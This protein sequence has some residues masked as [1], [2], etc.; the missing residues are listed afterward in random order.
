M[1]I[2]LSKLRRSDPLAKFYLK[3]PDGAVHG[4]LSTSELCKWSVQNRIPPGSKVSYD[5][6]IWSPAEMVEELKLEWDAKCADGRTMGPYNLLAIPVLVHDGLLVAGDTLVNRISNRSVQVRDL[7]KPGTTIVRRKAAALGSTTVAE[8][9]PAETSGQQELFDPAAVAPGKPA[10]AAAGFSEADERVR[11]ARRQAGARDADAGAKTVRLRESLEESV[12]ENARLKTD[13]DQERLRHAETLRVS[14]FDVKLMKERIKGLEAEQRELSTRLAD[15]LRDADALRKHE[16]SLRV[17]ARGD[18]PEKAGNGDSP[19]MAKLR[20]ALEHEKYLHGEAVKLRE[21]EGVVLKDRIREL[22][23]AQGDLL[24][25][26]TATQQS[27]EKARQGGESLLSVAMNK[28]PESTR[29]NAEFEKI[30]GSGAAEAAKLKAALDQEKALHAEALKQREHESRLLKDRIKALETDQRE[31]STRLGVAQQATD[32]ARQ[33]D[34][35]WRA[36]ARGREAELARRAS[37]LEKALNNSVAETTKARAALEQEK[38]QHAESRRVAVERDQHTAGRI[39]ELE[40]ETKNLSSRLALSTRAFDELTRKEE[41]LQIESRRKE[42]EAGQRIAQLEKSLGLASSDIAKLKADQD[43]EKAMHAETRRLAS[44]KEKQSAGRIKELEAETKELSAQLAAAQQVTVDAR[45]KDEAL[46]LEIRKKDA[47]TAQRMEQLRRSLEARVADVSRLKAEL[48]R[49][50]SLHAETRRL[51]GEREQQI[52]GRMKELE[53]KAREATVR[54]TESLQLAEDRKRKYEAIQQESRHRAGDADVRVEQ[55]EKSAEAAA[56]AVREIQQKLDDEQ[57]AHVQTQKDWRKK[58]QELTERIARMEVDAGALSG[59]L[60]QVRIDAEKQK[61]QDQNLIDQGKTR[62]TQ[63]SQ[64]FAQLQAEHEQGMIALEQARKKLAEKRMAPAPAPDPAVSERE[65]RLTMS[66]TQMEKQVSNATVAM[67]Q[68]KAETERLRRELVRTGERL[69]TSDKEARERIG[70]LERTVQ[71]AMQATEVARKSG[72]EQARQCRRLADENSSLSSR[73]PGL[74]GEMGTLKEA[75]RAANEELAA[76]QRKVD[77]AGRAMAQERKRHEMAMEAAGAER[78][79]LQ[80]KL[81][82][83]MQEPARVAERAGKKR[84]RLVT[85][86]I[87]A[88]AAV[89]AFLAGIGFRGMIGGS[90]VKEPGPV[91][92][93]AEPPAVEPPAATAVVQRLPAQAGTNLAVSRVAVVASTG[94]V[95][96]VAVQVVPPTLKWPEVAVDGVGVTRT[97]RAMVMVFSYGAFSSMANLREQAKTDLGL[98]A[99]QLREKMAGFTVVVVGHTDTVPLSTNTAYAG[100]YELGLARA[101]TAADYLVKECSMPAASVV[102]VSAGGSP[103]TPYPNADAESRKKNRTVVLR[104]VPSQD[105]PKIKA[106]AR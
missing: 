49:E 16:E 33:S 60:A 2:T 70:E 85:L 103:D 64:R 95:K 47:D 24:D 74:Q 87:A 26:L 92:M 100:N 68:A 69:S 14:E 72:E 41:T 50:K 65:K 104:L 51:D 79:K 88:T 27:A 59:V 75:V 42:E 20:T 71:V 97:D 56:K 29:R 84:A 15:A 1:S 82:S 35:A 21:T 96:T 46:Q 44:E 30:P 80:A 76:A 11:A 53:I 98:V 73:I 40:T 77:E 106:S 6:T 61:T 9:E 43:Y 31:L 39:K 8:D 19:E 45:Q 12:E 55:L 10:G 38:A 93:A 57:V 81:T 36:D 34:D 91:K 90:A 23:S 78:D 102:A 105:A 58:E 52:V 86:F 62:E 13:L 28:D 4:P 22:E 5:Q 17:A 66:L 99:Q 63:L 7:M 25:R 83:M 37:E 101:R 54:M 67:D 94:V 89:L 18:G 32:K 48:D 3:T